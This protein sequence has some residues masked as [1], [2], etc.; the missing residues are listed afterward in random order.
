[1][2]EPILTANP[3]QTSSAVVL[4]II[5]VV[6]DA[7]EE[8]TRHLYA[9]PASAVQAIIEV[10]GGIPRVLPVAP[11]AD[12]DACLRGL[13]GIFV[14]GSQTNVHPSR[15]GRAASHSD[16][17]FDRLRDDFVLQMIPRAIALK[18]PM[19]LTCR[20]FQELN[21]AFGGTL[22]KEPADLK[23]DC[24]HGA[25]ETDSEPER[26]RLRQKLEL[27]RNG[28]LHTIRGHQSVFVNS[29]HS[30][31]IENLASELK[32]EAR[33]VD[34]S[35]EAVSVSGVDTFVLGTAFHP[36]YWATSDP[37][38]TAILK[39]FGEAARAH[40]GSDWVAT[41]KNISAT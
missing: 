39:A 32:V 11:G 16:G 8:Q 2:R 20:G 1:V 25:P 10:A 28:L 40:A 22:R 27:V 17:P 19:L 9:A 14:P 41:G 34:G 21:V 30:V 13:D 12:V 26:Y 15:Y 33:A 18:I 29:L 38:S 7:I 24:K 6:S 36:E 37:P 5:G 35:V 23:D 3:S 31:L 4:P